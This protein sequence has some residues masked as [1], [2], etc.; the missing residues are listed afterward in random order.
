MAEFSDFRDVKLCSKSRK[1]SKKDKHPGKC[2]TN[3]NVHA[4]WETS[5]FQVRNALKREFKESDEQLR[6]DYERKSARFVELE[7]REEKVQEKEKDAGESFE[8]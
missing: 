7:D 1:C 8:L 5:R 2:D 3:R 4:F 6:A